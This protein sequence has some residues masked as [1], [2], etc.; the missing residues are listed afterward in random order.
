MKE[1]DPAEE[2]A[3]FVSRARAFRV[4]NRIRADGDNVAR[5]CEILDQHGIEYEVI[6]PAALS[7]AA[8]AEIED[9]LLDA[10]A[11]EALKKAAEFVAEGADDDEWE[12]DEFADAATT[13][14][15]IG[16]HLDDV[17]KVW[18]GDATGELG[19][20]KQMTPEYHIVTIPAVHGESGR[21]VLRFA[22]RLVSAQAAGGVHHP[23]ATVLA[24]LGDPNR[25]AVK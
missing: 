13:V 18:G 17:M 15:H 3:K 1:Y 4:K 25:A 24:V 10:W 14:W 23:A 12:A 11:D 21:A 22:D 6:Q 2:L 9:I 19:E 20:I 7:P 16:I 5:L 8:L